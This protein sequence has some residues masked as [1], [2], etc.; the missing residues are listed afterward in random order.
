MD[1]ARYWVKGEGE[2]IEWESREE[3]R[4]KERE[5]VVCIC[6]LIVNKWL[7]LQRFSTTSAIIDWLVGCRLGAYNNSTASDQNLKNKLLAK[8]EKEIQG[9]C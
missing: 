7:I 1:R 6:I 5:N 2:K 8:D 4:E 9:D 3:E